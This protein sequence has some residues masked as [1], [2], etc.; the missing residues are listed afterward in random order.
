PVPGPLALTPARFADL[1]GWKN[2]NP[3][4]AL[5]AFRR[6]CAILTG[7]PAGEKL[8]GYGGTAGDWRGVCAEAM[9][10]VSGAAA[11]RGFFE[12]SFNVFR[13]RAGQ[14]REGLFTGYYEPQ[15]RGSRT[16]H[17]PYRT[18]V[19]GTPADLVTVDLAQF[20]AALSKER[21]AGRLD[22]HKLV[23]YATRAEIDAGGL[24]P[25]PV[26]F[27]ADD[28]VSVFFLHIQGSG[29]VVF[30]DGKVERVAYDG[31]NGWPYTAIGRTLIHMGAIPR[32]AMS[33]QAIRDWLKAHPQRA[34]KV[35]ESDA[36][37]VF[38]RELPVGDP[39]LGA[40]GAQGVPLTPMASIAVDRKLHPFGAPFY[41]ATRTPDSGAPLDRLFIAQ[42]TGGA[43]AGPVRADIFF[44]FGPDAEG[45]AGAMKQQ[46]EM[47]VL[48]PKAVH[49][50]A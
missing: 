35:M 48:L 36:S 18:P 20:P 26:L 22:G 9:N 11:A 10:S 39:S 6:S 24:A 32:E 45:Q 1:P 41:I 31:Q 2:A 8:T 17:G 7:R 27:Y 4:S 30:D 5:E 12:R 3:Q 46:G 37:F 23:P 33:M 15:L 29:R 49:P 42:D 47:F 44:G 50:P 25:A 16:R 14:V 13:V 40:P 43:I 28:E 38:F 21:I 34:R 19:Y